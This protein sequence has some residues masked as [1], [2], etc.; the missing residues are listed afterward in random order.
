MQRP[1]AGVSSYV[2]E[3]VSEVER[4][5]PVEG[6]IWVGGARARA[7]SFFFYF[8]SFCYNCGVCFYDV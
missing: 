6:L 5:V 4:V 8:Y 3:K 1:F 2:V 7:V